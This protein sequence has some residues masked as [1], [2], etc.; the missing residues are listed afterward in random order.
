L[1][2]LKLGAG[3]A[4]YLTIEGLADYLKLAE[5]TIRRWVMNREIF[6]RKIKKV[7]R[8]RVFEIEKWVDKGSYELAEE[9]ENCGQEGVF[10]NTISLDELIEIEQTD[11]QPKEET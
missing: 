2:N 11:D 7:I 3:V 9:A 10:D 1:K 6:F 5:Q 8:L 4:T